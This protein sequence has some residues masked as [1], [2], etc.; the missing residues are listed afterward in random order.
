MMRRPTRAEVEA[1][2]TPRGGFTKAT[3]AQWGVPWPLTKGW[4]ERLLGEPEREGPYWV[5]VTA[6]YRGHCHRC[7][8]DIAP[9]DLIRWSQDEGACCVRDCGAG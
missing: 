7:G 9:G 6:R 1:A 4:I 8:A 3:V 2:R 5:E